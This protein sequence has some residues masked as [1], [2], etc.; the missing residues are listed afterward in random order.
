MGVYKR[1]TVWW[2]NLTSPNG[3]RICRSAGTDDQTRAQEFHDRLKVQLWEEQR[4][5]VKPDR[6]WQ[7]AAVRWVKETRDKRSHGKDVA[8]LRW[9][10]RF[11][12]HLRLSQVSRDVIDA[13]AERKTRES[14][15]S[16]AN[17]YLALI[18]AILRR[19]R[20]EWNW[21][22]A[23]P[24][25]RLSRE[26]KGRV[27]FLSPE[28]ARRLLDELPGHLRDMA[29]FA[30]ATGLRQ[31]NVSF[32]R[33]EQVDMA[34]RVAWIHPDEAKAGRAIGVPLNESAVAVLRQRLGQD[35]A[36]VFTYE[37]KPVARCSTKAWKAALARAGIEK[38]FRWHDLRHTWASWHVQNGTPLQELM[39]LGSWASYEMV[40]R[41][42]HLAADHLQGAACRIDA[43]FLP[44][45]KIPQLVR[46]A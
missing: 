40:L 12:G 14:S 30:L 21:L 11:L 2:V 37:G 22:D 27:R 24:K 16:N 36:H 6:S 5:G 43:T 20:D 8:K 44:Q 13:I 19:A 1:G 10:D 33:W 28:E 46:A 3:T 45:T 25:V 29:Q 9:L 26:P 39:E 15:P 17:R 23:I 34:R 7:D 18:R 32:L 38:T 42:A 35:N 41:Y 4:L 31:R